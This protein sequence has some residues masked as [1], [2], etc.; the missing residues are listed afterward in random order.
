MPGEGACA[1]GGGEGV[2]DT[3]AEETDRSGGEGRIKPEY[4]IALMVVLA[5]ETVTRGGSIALWKDRV[6]EAR[7]GDAARSH[8]ERL[9]GEVLAFLGDQ[10]VPLAAVDVFAVVTGPG[11]FTGLRVGIA[12]VQGL[13]LAGHRRVVGVST[14]E[15]LTAAWRVDHDRNATVVACLDGQRGE[16]FLAATSLVA[17]R[18]LD[19][20]EVVL[21]PG[22]ATAA[23]AA[24]RIAGLPATA[25][26]L[27]IVGDGAVRYAEVFRARLPSASIVAAPRPI[28]HGAVLLAAA[29][30]DRATAPHAL[31]AVYLR[32]PDVEIARDRARAAHAARPSPDGPFTVRRAGSSADLDAVEALQR[33]TFTN[34]WGAEAI[35]WELE[36]TDVARL[37]VLSEPGGG[38]VAYCS[39]WVVF[40]ELHINSLAVD[41][42]WRRRGVARRLLHHVMAESASGGAASATLEVRASNDAARQ[43]YEG[44]G[45][46]IEGVRRDYYRDPREDA[47]ILWNRT[48]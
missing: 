23:D 3:E 30:V 28:A 33:K 14:L 27:V 32:R 39:C 37:Y 36:N 7:T 5:L 26:D 34:P 2:D 11:S 48:L 40:D 17:G 8:A 41:P 38:T 21:A 24:A 35:R 45:F 15:A 12:A 10:D 42:A 18:P 16:V 1:G 25:D 44:L 4:N 47:L 6:V 13:A 46:R 9:P 19:E 43:L 20:C 22:V 31:R 29:R